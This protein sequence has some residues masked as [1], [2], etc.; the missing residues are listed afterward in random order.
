MRWLI[1]FPDLIQEL[2]L[3]KQ[4]ILH[5]NYIP[6][7]D[8]KYYFCASDMVVQPYRTATQSGI[9]QIAYHFERPMLVTN[10]G[11][12]PEIVPDG[13]VGYVVEPKP[14]VI[15]SAIVNFY[16]E[17]KEEEFSSN[18]RIE[19]DRFKWSSFVNGLLNLV[20]SL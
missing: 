11:G 14:E 16:Q 1:L 5:T 9:T 4:L 19:K 20:S 17:N 13:K 7:Q 15:A 8:V 3:E 18:T 6:A 2:G 12:L 10:T